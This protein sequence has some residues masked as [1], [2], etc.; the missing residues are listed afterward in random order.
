[1]RRRAAGQEPDEGVALLF[2]LLCVLISTGL[3]VGLLGVLLGE[4]APTVHERKSAR[5]IAASQAGLQ[6][7]LA[8]V[9]AATTVTPGVG[10]MGDRAKLPC[11]ATTP[12]TGTVGGTP[13][14]LAYEVRIRY[15]TIDPSGQSNTWR[16]ASS[17]QVTCTPGAG[18]ATTP[19]YAL[20]ES[21]ATGDSA[22]APLGPTWGDRSSEVVYSL[23]RTDQAFLGG[24]ILT[25]VGKRFL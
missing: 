4:L 13:G 11:L 2:V 25:V 12:L 15:Y 23:N 19:L 17:N 18:T 14:A 1:M 16:S 3:T 10:T 7:G 9:R 21:R 20:V 22:G 24:L 8:A 6:A 5:T